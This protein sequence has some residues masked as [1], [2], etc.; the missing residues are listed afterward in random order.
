MGRGARG[1]RGMNLSKGGK[2]IALLVAENETQSVLTA[3]ENG[4]G[5]RTPIAEYTR[6]GRGTQGMIAIQTSERN[7]KVCAATL[8][9]ADDEIML[10]T[11]GGVLIR[12]RVNEIREM[13]RSTQGVTLI[14]LSEGEKLSGLQRIMDRDDE[15]GENGNGNGN[16]TSAIAD[17]HGDDNGGEPPPH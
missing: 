11:N 7:G 8:A 15:N 2:V 13:G 4:Y 14:N 16:A 1:V 10:I 9:S 12:T 5:K 17:G 6:H 3:T